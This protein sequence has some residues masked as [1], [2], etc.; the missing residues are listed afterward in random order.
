MTDL[1]KNNKVLNKCMA[2]SIENE[3]KHIV[4][5]LGI[6]QKKNVRFS[7]SLCRKDLGGWFGSELFAPKDMKSGK[8]LYTFILCLTT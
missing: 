5:L 2:W 8:N 3:I 7:Q 1:K 4:S 6:V